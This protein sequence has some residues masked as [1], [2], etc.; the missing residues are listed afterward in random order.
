MTKA[1]SAKGVN[2][3]VVIGETTYKFQEVK[4]VPEVGQSAD[5]I[6]ATHL[7][8]EMKEYVKDI[9][10]FSSDLEF[11]MNAMPTGSGTESAPGN[12]DLIAMMDEK[13]ADGQYTFTIAYPQTGI[14]CEIVGQYSWRMG[15]GEVSSIQDIIFTII[16]ASAPV[17]GEV[18]TTNTVTYEEGSA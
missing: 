15:G 6:D 1:T 12:Y 5:K 11:T 3:S 2:L 14:K 16:P 17:W 8:S 10:D 4:S 9:P 18:T 13:D 7:D